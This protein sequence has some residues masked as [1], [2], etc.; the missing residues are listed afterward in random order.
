[1]IIKIFLDFH[2][3]FSGFRRAVSWVSPSPRWLRKTN[4]LQLGC[5]SL[6]KVAEFGRAGFGVSWAALVAS[7]P[8][9]GRSRRFLSRAGLAIVTKFAAEFFGREILEMVN[10]GRENL[11]ITN[12][13]QEI[14]VVKAATD[15]CGCECLEMPSFSLEILD[16]P[17]F[18]CNSSRDFSPN[19]K[20]DLS[21]LSSFLTI[22]L[23]IL[24]HNERFK[25]FIYKN[26]QKQ[27]KK[28]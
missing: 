20:Q 10:L 17:N 18:G 13:G 16:I 8:E 5:K 24:L 12:L 25:L 9:L 26:A 3:L 1:M 27:R 7:F 19:L 2:C 11:D 22:A 4:R 14:S 23:K 6:K 15:H 28:I 21:G